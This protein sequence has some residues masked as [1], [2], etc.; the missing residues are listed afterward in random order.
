MG[1][2]SVLGIGTRG[3][4]ASQLG[5]DVTGQN[6]SNADVEGY[7]RKR[8]NITPDYRYDGS[9]GQM[10]FGVEVVNIERIRNVYIDEQIRRQNREVG[11]YEE[12]DHTLERVENVFIEPED[13]GL[14][15]Y[16][17]E[18]FN[19]WQNLTKYPDDVAA[20]TMTKTNA[21]ILVDVFHNLSGELRDIRETRNDE[22][23]QRVGKVNELSKE[24][25]NL[26]LEIA[27]VEIGDQNAND[28][29]DRRDR[30]LK[31]L[32]KLIDI[33]TTE[34]ERGQV[35]VTTMGNIIVSPVDSQELEISTKTTKRADGTSFAEVSVRFSDSNRIYEPSG[36]QLKGLFESR[37]TIVPEYQ[38]KLDKIA[39]TIVEKVNEIHISGYNLHGYSGINF[40]DPSLT[41]ASDIDVSASILQDV[42][43][44]AAAGDAEEKNGNDRINTTFGASPV[45]LYDRPPGDPSRQRI[46]N[47]MSGSVVVTNGASGV[48][49]RPDVDYHV[50]YTLGQIQLLNAVHDGADLDV[51][52]KYRTGTYAGPGDNSNAIAIAQLREKLVMEPDAH[53][54]NTATL[55]Q[56]YGSYI[57]QL[58]LN[59]NEA[60][61][62]LE[63]RN[64]LIRQFETHQDSIAG[65]S[66]DEEM[67]ELIKYQHTYQASA[68]LIST[69]ERMLDV[70]M[71]M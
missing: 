27:H 22:I 17:D 2:F 18:F 51:E 35:T 63:T 14:Q 10:G 15:S 28:S 1:L 31:E 25:F 36:G 43:N 21:E 66:L 5:M 54:R 41:G 6:I 24:I 37:D 70:L 69:A 39:R 48:V 60:T 19:S 49:L 40:F 3:L 45:Q 47:V 33:Q 58:G 30:L 67:A 20:R 42:Q 61:S 23:K 52:F 62:H 46:R 71:N 38:Q 44:I 50:D 56:F 13:T 26:N 11:Y 16:L 34:N 7:S 68:R 59:R 55:N 32:S 53:G 64:Y 29:R 12:I 57:G 65:V 8:L 9:Y 4:S